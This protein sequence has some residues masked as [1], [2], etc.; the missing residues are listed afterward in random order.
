MNILGLD[1]STAAAAACVLR[2]DGVAFES[3][4]EPARLSCPPAHARELMP[5]VAGVLEASEV[6]WNGLDAIAAGVGPGSFTGLRIGVASARA[7]AAARDLELRPVSSLAALAAGIEG[8]LRLPLLDARRREVAGALYEEE[9]VR[10]SEFVGS[11]EELVERLRNESLRPFAAGEGSLRFRE[12]LEAAGVEI[13][14]AE[15]RAHVVRALHICRLAASAD[16]VVP[17]ALLPN[18]LRRPDTS[19]DHTPGDGISS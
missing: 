7:L 17:E 16:A 14:P 10:W 4:V 8:S 19:L 3:P 13:A 9:R 2:S 15:S 18:Y 11:P 12:A 5:L 6:G 1:T